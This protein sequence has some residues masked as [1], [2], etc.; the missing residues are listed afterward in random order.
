[1]TML[2]HKNDVFF[3]D[4]DMESMTLEQVIEELGYS[5]YKMGKSSLRALLNGEVSEARGFV[6]ADSEEA[7]IPDNTEE[8]VVVAEDPQPEVLVEIQIPVEE[9]V[10]QEP[11]Q[12]HKKESLLVPTWEG[13]KNR[14]KK[15]RNKN[16]SYADHMVDCFREV[17]K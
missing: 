8:P 2:A 4:V 3:I 7:P 14:L 13:Y 6:I 10:V 17:Y 11:I 1:M 15:G 5:G 9:V 12:K 16:L